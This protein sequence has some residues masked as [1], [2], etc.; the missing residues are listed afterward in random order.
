MK[1]F[2]KD[3]RGYIN[4]AIIALG[5]KNPENAIKSLSPHAEK[6]TKNFTFQYLIGTAYYQLRDYENSKIY[7]K[8]AL[9]IYPHSKNTKHNLALIY[10]AIGEW[11]NQ[12]NYI[13]N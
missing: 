9:E 4:N 10:D 1:I 7:L 5:D 11:E 12:I 3:P 8:N 13:W 2:Q 6:F